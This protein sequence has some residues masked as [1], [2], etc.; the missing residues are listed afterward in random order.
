[1]TKVGSMLLASSLCALTCACASVPL[2]RKGGLSSYEGMTK[3][4]GTRA[5]AFIRFDRQALAGVRTVKIAPV[6]FA[7]ATA[8]AQITQEQK[9]LLAANLSRELCDRLAK[10]YDIMAPDQPADLTVEARVTYIGR[11]GGGLSAVSVAAARLSP[12]PFTPRLPVG[13]GGLA[14]EA[15]AMKPGGESAAAM[16]WARG[17]DPFTT[18]ARVSAIGDAYALSDAFAR[19]FGDMLV[20]HSDP[21]QPKPERDYAVRKD[22]DPQCAPYG[23]NPG[24]VDFVAK[25]LGAPPEW[26]DKGAVDPST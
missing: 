8:A 9:D 26:T 4:K 22:D 24:L 5:K 7:P 6:A 14:G 10:R 23:K 21:F 3:V 13:M 17:A 18:N 19:D 1:M 12:I 11:T 25:R 15:Q 20:T 16:V 2:E